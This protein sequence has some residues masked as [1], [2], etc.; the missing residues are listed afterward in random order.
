MLRRPPRST[1]KPSSAASDV[2]KRQGDKDALSVISA[3][4]EM[5][6]VRESVRHLLAEC[7]DRG[8]D[9]SRVGILLRS[10]EPY[11]G[12]LKQ[13][14]DELS[15]EPYLPEAESLAN[16]HWG[17]CALLLLEVLTHDYARHK[18]MEFVKFAK[19][20]TEAGEFPTHR[21]DLLSI[22]AGIVKGKEEWKDRLKRLIQENQTESHTD[23]AVQLK[24]TTSQF[25]KFIEQAIDL[26]DS[27]KDEP[28]WTG[29][30]SALNNALKQLVEE[31]ADSASVS[32]AISALS[33]LDQLGFEP[34]LDEF[35][36]AVTEVLTSS[37]ISQ[38]HFQRNGPAVLNLMAARGLD[39]DLV[40]IPGL[41]DGYL[42]PRLQEDPILTDSERAQLNRMISGDENSPIALK[43]KQRFEAVSYTHL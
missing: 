17:R 40:V 33:S 3:P 21:W 30:A 31:D 36:N 12:L 24:K 5:R 1:P 22:D 10:A 16:T 29:K 42:P 20:R 18:L 23:S 19:L 7:L 37:P 27:I 6:E 2:Y 11:A 41:V 9:L 8:I 35:T 28:T 13:V 25:Y 32:T 26:I 14:F 43:A 4:G 34:D 39:F 15:I 38:G